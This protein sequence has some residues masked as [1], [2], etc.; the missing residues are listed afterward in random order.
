M[1]VG[2]LEGVADYRSQQVSCHGVMDHLVARHASLNR[3][4]EPERLLWQCVFR[5]SG[6][7][8]LKADVNSRREVKLV[9]RKLLIL[10]HQAVPQSFLKLG[11]GETIEPN[12]L[13]AGSSMSRQDNPSIKFGWREAEEQKTWNN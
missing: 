9:A 5:T 3:H 4:P 6:S 8:P 10:S 11:S 1:F 7:S 12:R 13:S 2:T